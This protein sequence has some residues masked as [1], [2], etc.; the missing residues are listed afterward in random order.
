MHSWLWEP[1]TLALVFI[2]PRIVWIKIISLGF[3]EH[4]ELVVVPCMELWTHSEI[5]LED[6]F[7]FSL[8]RAQIFGWMFLAE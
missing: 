8:V 7:L 1:L 5:D 6:I 2:K 4:L 3:N